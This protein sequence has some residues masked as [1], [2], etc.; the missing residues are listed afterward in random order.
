MLAKLLST[1]SPIQLQLVLDSERFK[2]ACAGRRCLVKGTMVATPSGPVAIE[3]LRSGDWVYSEKAVPIQVVRTFDQGVQEVV[4]LKNNGSV[5]AA[6]TDN[7]VWWTVGSGVRTIEGERRTDELYK[8]RAIA[9]V[10]Y[11]SPLG[12]V[13]E[14]HAYAI[15]ALLGDGCSREAGRSLSIS[16][17]TDAIPSRVSSVLGALRVY[18]QHADNYTWK[19]SNR[20]THLSR[21]QGYH[22][23]YY[24]AVQ[25][26]YYSEWCEGRYA[27]DKVVDL[28]VIRTWDRDS[29]LAL[30]AGLLDT[31]GSVWDGLD[32]LTV[33]WSSQSRS[34]IA[35]LEY[36]CL[37]LWGVTLQVRIDTR[38]KYV[39]GP[40]FDA[41]I[42]HI[43]HAK[44]ML[45][46]LTPFLVTP[47][48]MYKSAWDTRK[49]NNFCAAFLGVTRGRR[50]LAETYD[51]QVDSDTH[52]FLLANGLVSHNSG[53]SYADSVYLIYECLKAPN[54]PTLYLGLTR[55][56]AKEAIWDTLIQ[57][58][59]SLGI[60]HEARPSSL[61]IRFPNGS[62]IT[63]FGADT[64]NAR[65]RLRGRKF[66]LIVADEMGFFADADPLV[67]ALLPSLADYRGS[68]VMTSSPGEVLSGLFYDAYEGKN[69]TKW[70]QYHW[71]MR[72]NP[73]F[74]KP[75][76]N[77]VFESFADEEMQVVCDQ[78]FGGDR[79]HPAFKREYLAIYIADNTNK[80]YPYTRK[81]LIDE[82]YPMVKEMYGIGID[83]GSVSENAIVVVK[84]SAYA[85][86]VQ[87]VE[88]WKEAGLMI[89]ELAD[90]LKEF[91]DRFDPA[92]VVADTGGYGKGV[93][94]ELRRRY[95]LPIKAAEKTDKSF[96]QR[97]FANDLLSNY[98]KV[99]RTLSVVGE[100]DKILRDEEGDEIKGQTNHAADATLYIYRAIYNTHLKTF[101]AAESEEDKMLRQ[102]TEQLQLE[103]DETQEDIL[104][105]A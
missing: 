25:C 59:E 92:I 74:M 24:A 23:T 85:R 101:K 57:I 19:I 6:A 55:D 96:Y 69:R 103:R 21:G 37:A 39:N 50:M 35:A 61:Y 5:V 54:M 27:H 64:P 14:P 86:E 15:G 32:G 91:I 66:K 81:N 33:S 10:E 82:S 79:N 67:N 20:P 46:E 41:K 84:F 36:A 71:T 48:K 12:S 43:Y 65:N 87:V 73:H 17:E 3:D 9:R 28:S 95:F 94:E 88:C 99:I 97:V 7:H 22:S 40:C 4:Q 44:R 62:R 42:K 60:P 13:S 76:I 83:L 47:R 49:S 80:V 90:V 30:V 78:R 52:L 11:T 56:S 34:I 63:L 31:D 105:Y 70:K 75:A 89:D 72:D 45:R 68:L 2:V 29:L 100:W 58:L 18:R 77:P 1:L 102:A 93:V 8:G 104:D 53:K 51:I 26:N 16:S 98:I 38:A